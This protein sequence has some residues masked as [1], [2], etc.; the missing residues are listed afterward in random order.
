VF[1]SQ[2][3]KATIA[4]TAKDT[5][6]AAMTRCLPACCRLLRDGECVGCMHVPIVV[7][8]RFPC[9]RQLRPSTKA[10]VLAVEPE[11]ENDAA[12]SDCFASSFKTDFC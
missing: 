3:L 2:P 8:N 11:T 4:A 5:R 10:T 12:N 1:C 9:R 6:P 7:W